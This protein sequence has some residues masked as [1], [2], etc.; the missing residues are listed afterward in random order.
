MLGG[1]IGFILYLQNKEEN[2]E[3][4]PKVELD[5]SETIDDFTIEN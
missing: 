1:I 3:A 4:K 2:R 5:E